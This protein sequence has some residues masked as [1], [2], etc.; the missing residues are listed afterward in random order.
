MGVFSPL[1]YGVMRVIYEA[2][3]PSIKQEEAY[4]GIGANIE[5]S[6]PITR[7]NSIS[8]DPDR[9][10]EAINRLR[11]VCAESFADGNY[12]DDTLTRALPIWLETILEDV[13][14]DIV[15]YGFGPHRLGKLLETIRQTKNRLDKGTY[16][17]PIG[18]KCR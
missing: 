3:F 4:M 2:A 17:R 1:G 12:N 13:L 9:Y 16:G 5:R 11:K 15:E 18:E 14:D 7:R 8:I 6:R 10:E